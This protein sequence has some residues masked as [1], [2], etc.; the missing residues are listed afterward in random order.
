VRRLFLWLTV[1]GIG[2]LLGFGYRT[3]VD[4]EPVATGSEVQLSTLVGAGSGAADAASPRGPMPV[5]RITVEASS[6]LAPFSDTL[7]YEVTNMLDGDPS[8]AWNS[9]APDADGRGEVLTFRFTEPVELSAVRIVNGYAKSP[10]LFAA[11]HRISRATVRT[12]NATT[13][14]VLLDVI[15]EQEIAL[16]VGPTAKLEIQVDDVFV[17][18]GFDNP[19][20]TADLAVSEIEFW[21]A[22]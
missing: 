21:T 15:A 11:N 13:E 4:D 6:T 19:E 20:L 12:D 18:D 8:T 2:A 17:G 14:I 5:D 16:T 7:T 9:D 10:D 22:G 3:L 1:V